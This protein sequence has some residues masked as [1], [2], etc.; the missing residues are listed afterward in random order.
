ML[1]YKNAQVN[2]PKH[3][4]ILRGRSSYFGG[5]NWIKRGL[6]ENCEKRVRKSKAKN[7]FSIALQG[8]QFLKIFKNVKWTAV[9]LKGCNV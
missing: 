2:Y 8:V 6:K 1:P 3:K 7:V 4:S 9:V 5:L